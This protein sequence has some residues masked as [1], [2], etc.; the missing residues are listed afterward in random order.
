MTDL[1]ISSHEAEVEMYVFKKCDTK[2]G[3][4]GYQRH[5]EKEWIKLHVKVK[6]SNIPTFIYFILGITE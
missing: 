4:K 2:S 1:T 6:D 5:I 3:I